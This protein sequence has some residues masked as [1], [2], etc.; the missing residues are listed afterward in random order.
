M[1]SYIVLSITLFATLLF[2]A[3]GEIITEKSGHL[4]LGTPG[5]MCIGGIGGGYGIYLYSSMVGGVNNVNGFF[6]VLFG[7]VFALIFGALAG[8]LYSFLTVTL[9]ANQNI[10]GLTI[11]TLG[12]GLANF[13]GKKFD[14]TVLSKTFQYFQNLFHIGTDNDALRIFFSYGIMVYLG[15]IIA[16]LAILFLKKTKVGLELRA[17]GENPATADATGIS[18]SKY[19]YIATIVGSSIAALGGLAYIMDFSS[20]KFDQASSIEALGWLSVAIVIFSVWNPGIC[21]FS[22]A[23]FSFLF[24]L[25]TYVVATTADKELIKTISYVVTIVVLIITSIVGKRSVQ[26]PAA[27][28]SNYFRE[29]R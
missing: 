25:P 28:G 7:I 10:T 23:L 8:L 26:P 29:D 12:V 15:I 3:V 14:L 13:M 1:V 6:V 18:V 27:L 9:R 16:I 20:G 22:S 4:N 19:R 2:G 24:V 17:V 21:I 5:I 11:T